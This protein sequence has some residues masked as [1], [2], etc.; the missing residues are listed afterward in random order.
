M[1]GPREE[2]KYNYS[3]T[4]KGFAGLKFRRRKKGESNAG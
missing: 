3:M 2:S 1:K 4:N